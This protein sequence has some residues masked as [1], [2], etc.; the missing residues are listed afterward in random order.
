M[1]NRA[2][3]L[4]A[5]FSAFL[6]FL[7]AGQLSAQARSSQAD[8]IC[9]MAAEVPIPQADLPPAGATISKFCDPWDM[10][11]GEGQPMDLQGAR[12]CA[13]SQLGGHGDVQNP[14][15]APAV[16]T[17]IY[18]NGKGVA[19]NL[20]LAIKFACE[21]DGGWDDA[22]ALV[23]MLDANRK[24]GAVRVDLDVC[25]NPTGRQM[26]YACLIRDET[27]ANNDVS[28]AESQLDSGS[29]A[30]QHDLFEDLLEARRG[31]LDAHEA[32]E[33]TGTVGNAQDII[34][35]NVAT[36]KAWAELLTNLADGK[37]PH[38]TQEEF[39]KADADLNAEYRDARQRT[40][41]CAVRSCTS[42]DAVL[43]AERE[44]LTYREAFVS[45]AK[46]RW[47]QVPSDTWRTLLTLERT[48]M[49]REL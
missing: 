16:L 38:F 43:Q 6:I 12:Y 21:I 49:L 28:T 34:F 13:F 22:S 31:F 17:M 42:S 41:G 48:K 2:V 45:Y 20:S 39:K 18:A 1:I 40:A 7:F 23:K 32:E 8:A 11:Y 46:V 14:I 9:Q 47:P 10:Y 25:D 4:P 3:G 30:A 26:N 29:N 19:P 5:I 36:Q 44:W 24:Q 15:E 33:P 37:L 35:E 27:R